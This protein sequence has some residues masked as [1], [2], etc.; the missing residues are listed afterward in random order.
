MYRIRTIGVQQLR[1]LVA[2]FAAKG[3]RDVYGLDGWE[4]LLEVPD[5]AADLVEQMV[6]R[7]RQSNT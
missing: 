7:I 3:V 5:P 1:Q 2:Q 6:M 4:A